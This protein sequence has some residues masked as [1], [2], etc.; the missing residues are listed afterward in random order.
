[1]IRHLD[2][3]HQAQIRPNSTNSFLGVFTTRCPAERYQERM[4]EL[5][6]DADVPPALLEYEQWVCWRVQSRGEKPTKIPVNPITGQYASTNKPERWV[7][8]EDAVAHADDNSRNG[9]GFVFT[10]DDPFV[11]VDLDAVRDLDGETADW[12]VTIINQ[13]DSYTETS[14][15]GTGY[16]VLVKDTLPRDGIAVVPSNST[17][18]VAFLPSP[19]IG[20]GGRPREFTIGQTHSRPSTTSTSHQT[21][22]RNRTSQ[23]RATT[24]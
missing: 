10:E 7:C 22:R 20:L 8:F 2:H 9:V 17:R 15:S 18:T 13:L 5:P 12:A 19:V 1:M 23:W 16:H 24:K 4:T 6:T 21:M 11:G 3:F 14:P